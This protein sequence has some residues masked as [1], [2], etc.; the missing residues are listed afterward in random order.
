MS[1]APC[2]ST[3]SDDSCHYPDTS[4]LD[5]FVLN[6]KGRIW[7]GSSYSNY[8]RPWQFAQF[9]KDSL[10]VSLWMLNKLSYKDRGDP[11]KARQCVGVCLCV[12]QTLGVAHLVIVQM[13]WSIQ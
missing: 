4:D 8:G 12:V 10:E 13:L 7:V 11:I 2:I 9:Q 6:N 5:E 1:F 3:P